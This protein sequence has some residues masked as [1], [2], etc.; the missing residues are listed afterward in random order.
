MELL[1]ECV[2]VN[3]DVVEA[4][5]AIEALSLYARRPF[6]VV[7]TDFN[8]P[9]MQGD[10]LAEELKSFDPAQR[11]ILIT[12]YAQHVKLKRQAL[13]FVDEILP[14]PC[15][16]EQLSFAMARSRPA[17]CPLGVPVALPPSPLSS[18]LN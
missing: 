2:H 3:A 15:T 18:Q 13:I 12:G 5:D 14:K 6:D 17:A 10:E 1:T 8:L 9:G 11:V 4:E 16:L 7:L